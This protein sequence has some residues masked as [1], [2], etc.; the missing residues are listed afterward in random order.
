MGNVGLTSR[1]GKTSKEYWG[2]K[3]PH[4]AG[5]CHSPSH[6]AILHPCPSQGPH[7]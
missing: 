2:R 4:V 6:P 3:T 1:V 5:K 7:P